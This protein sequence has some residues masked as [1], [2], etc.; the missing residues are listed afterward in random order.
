VVLTRSD[1][2]S[3]FHSELKLLEYGTTLIHFIPELKSTQ[4]VTISLLDI[5]YKSHHKKSC[6]LITTYP[7]AK[8]F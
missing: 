7:Y 2:F 8:K 5:S 1:N 3:L 6:Q 4:I